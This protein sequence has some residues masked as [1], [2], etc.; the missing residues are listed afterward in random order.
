MP[1]IQ[2]PPDAPALP[3][4]IEAEAALL[5]AMMIDNR[6]CD[7]IADIL[8]PEHFFEQ[9]HGR[10]FEA[11]Q[12]EHNAGRRATPVTLRP[13]FVD[14]PAIKEVGGPAYLAQLTGSGAALVGAMDFAAQIK[15]LAMLRSL[16][17]LGESIAAR[18]RDTSLDVDPATQLAEA[19]SE[20][21]AITGGTEEG[22][23]EVSAGEAAERA[24]RAG[25]DTTQ[26]GVFCGIA[27]IDDALGPLRRKEF[28][29]VG[30]RPGMGKSALGTGYA[31]GAAK[32]GLRLVEDGKQEEKIGVLYVSLEM[33]AEQLGARMLSDLTFQGDGRAVPYSLVETGKM[34][35]EQI[36]RI[37]DAK[38]ELNELPVYVVDKASLTVGQ[39]NSLIRRWKRR[40]KA[41]GISLELVIVDYVQLMRAN[42]KTRDRIEQMTEV[43]IG[44]KAAAK[45]NDVAVM[46]LAQL[47]RAVENRDDKRPHLSDLRESG[48][49]EQDADA[50]LFLFR[51]EYYL[52]A[53]APAEDAPERAAWESLMEQ[54][55]NK[56]EFI[57]AKR[58][59]RETGK[60]TGQFFGAFAA[61]RAIL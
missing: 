61:M 29:V 7:R 41:K 9:L 36:R 11:V 51:K 40:L 6:L 55:R 57:C 23:V 39:L 13:F 4:N 30:G 15:A 33:S 52:T 12:R 37:F 8:A 38:D 34:G 43:S 3:H 44:L 31:V 22:T 47:S 18:A 14:D 32:R 27:P 25:E 16:V 59:Q 10:I 35:R 50:I 19:E 2:T 58:R 20:L 1:D 60:Q 54:V 49:L 26:G 28:I 21:S 46:G 5:G 48:Q 24:I 53:D 56:I 17:A 45:A 42:H